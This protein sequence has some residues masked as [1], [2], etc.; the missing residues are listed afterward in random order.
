LVGGLVGWW[1]GGLVGR[2]VGGSVV[3]GLLLGLEVLVLVPKLISLAD[4]GLDSTMASGLTTLRTLSVDDYANIL[5]S[6]HINEL[7]HLCQI[8]PGLKPL[9]DDRQFW[10]DQAQ[11]N[12]DFPVEIF[13]K[14]CLPHSINLYIE[15]AQACDKELSSYRFE[16]SLS[17]AIERGDIVV[18]RY[19]LSMEKRLDDVKWKFT[20]LLSVAAEVANLD[21]LKLL[22]EFG[23][24][25]CRAYLHESVDKAL[26]RACYKGHNTVVRYLHDQIGGRYVQKTLDESL[27]AAAHSGDLELVKYWL[28]KGAQKVQEALK[29]ACL[30]HRV[31]VIHHL[32]SL[33]QVDLSTLL[34]E[35]VR[36][37]WAPL[38]G[39]EELVLAGARDLDRAVA[40]AAGNG[41]Y[42]VV[43]SLI[44][45]GAQPKS[46]SY[47]RHDGWLSPTG[48]AL[49]EA[50]VRA[51]EQK[52]FDVIKFVST[53]YQKKLDKSKK[54]KESKKDKKSKKSKKSEE[55]YLEMD[56]VVIKAAQAGHVAI[57]EFLMGN[58]A[59][60][61][62]RDVEA[63][64]LVNRAIVK[65]NHSGKR[66]DVMMITLLGLVT[67]NQEF[68]EK[69]LVGYATLADYMVQK[70]TRTFYFTLKQAV[71]EHRLDIIQLVVRTNISS[72]HMENAAWN[73]NYDS[74]NNEIR[75]YLLAAARGK[76]ERDYSLPYVLD[77]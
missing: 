9:S 7:I 21:I 63:L 17:A 42:D 70:K 75:D 22:M 13:L 2:R 67:R 56:T 39:I 55:T 35:V 59:L 3:E 41:R 30:Y 64:E 50:V 49:A 25:H 38:S 53:L 20:E 15:I 32:I 73:M 52:R 77:G 1:V 27:A 51:F 71:E 5:L 43:Q 45:S 10:A 60:T 24:Q 68:T 16:R 4:A 57:V 36:Y 65:A 18:I 23:K 54:S 61:D 76:I 69:Q 72:S 37:K 74:Q 33:N 34:H 47:D 6:L 14:S 31:E 8:A 29:E 40:T 66:N 26:K 58:G 48:K 46:T 11:K 19:W 28:D 12:F 62:Q 44:D